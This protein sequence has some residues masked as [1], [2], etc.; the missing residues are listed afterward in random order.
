MAINWDLLIGI[1]KISRIARVTIGCLVLIKAFC[2]D[3]W[4]IK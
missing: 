4:I 2:I 3:E 1:K